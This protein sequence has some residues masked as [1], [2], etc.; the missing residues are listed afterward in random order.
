VDSCVP[1]PAGACESSS[2]KTTTPSLRS[3]RHETSRTEKRLTIGGDSA[4]AVRA[5]PSFGSRI[6]TTVSVP[7][8]CTRSSARSNSQH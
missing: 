8:P 1:T 4:G 3:S 5:V 7:Y 6:G 2:P